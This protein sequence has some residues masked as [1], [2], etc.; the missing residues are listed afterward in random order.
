M[1]SAHCTLL[2]LIEGEPIVNAFPV[3]I[4][5]SQYVSCLKKLIQLKSSI[6]FKQTNRSCINLWRVSIPFDPT[7]SNTRPV[8]PEIDAKTALDPTSE[9]SDVFREPP[10]EN[11]IHIIL[12]RP[13]NP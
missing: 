6:R 8:L 1:P 5:L 13:P 12:Q 11:T 3:E 10:P 4:E 7:G 9:I 2:C